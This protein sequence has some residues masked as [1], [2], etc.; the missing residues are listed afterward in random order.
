[1]E[2]KVICMQCQNNG[3][4]P[5]EKFFLLRRKCERSAIN[6]L[7]FRDQNDHSDISSDIRLYNKHQYMSF[8][9]SVP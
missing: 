8:R 2:G 1:M 6:V 3:Y 5:N 4:Y 7:N 9:L